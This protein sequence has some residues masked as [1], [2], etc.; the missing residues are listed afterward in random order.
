MILVKKEMDLLHDTWA[1]GKRSALM[2]EELGVL[3]QVEKIVGEW[4]SDTVPD[5]TAV[6]DFL[7]F[8]GD[9]IADM[10]GYEDEEDMVAHL[11]GRDEEEEYE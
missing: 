3:K 1:G 7:W 6:N 11:E 4:F 2:Y 9:T 8:E 5:E 10:L